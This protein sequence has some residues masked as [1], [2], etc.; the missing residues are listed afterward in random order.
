MGGAERG[1]N[2]RCRLQGVEPADVTEK[3]N[4]NNDNN[5]N[6]EEGEGEGGHE[7]PLVPFGIPGTWPRVNSTTLLWMDGYDGFSIDK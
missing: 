3:E 1:L 2:G 6:D 4:E 7:G 5:L